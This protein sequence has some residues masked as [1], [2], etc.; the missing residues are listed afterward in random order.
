VTTTKGGAT[1][2]KKVCRSMFSQRKI[3]LL[4]TARVFP[5]VITAQKKKTTDKDSL[6]TQ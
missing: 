6:S 3:Q 5:S 4:L 2:V 1:S